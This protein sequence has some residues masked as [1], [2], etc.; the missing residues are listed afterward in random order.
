MRNLGTDDELTMDR[1]VQVQRK[2]EE[3]ERRITRQQE[4]V[5]K[6]HRDGRSTALAQE[7]LRTLEQSQAMH[8]AEA[9]RQLLKL[10]RAQSKFGRR[11]IAQELAPSAVTAVRLNE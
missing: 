9:D 6:L 1:L 11:A 5:V 8:V 7:V 3:G 2:V 4:I 10:C